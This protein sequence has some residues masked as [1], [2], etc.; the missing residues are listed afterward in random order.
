MKKTYINPECVAYKVDTIL[1]I[2]LSSNL[3]NERP[4]NDDDDNQ[5]VKEDGAWDGQW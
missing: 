5:F 4:T 1:P 2:A 3:H